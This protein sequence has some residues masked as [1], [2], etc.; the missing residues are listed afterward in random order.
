MTAD[1]ET[2][3]ENNEQPNAQTTSYKDFSENK[4][5]HA[6]KSGLTST[7]FATK[8]T[9]GL[10]TEQQ[11]DQVDENH[12]VFRRGSTQI[13]VQTYAASSASDVIDESDEESLKH[14]S[15]TLFSILLGM[16][17]LIIT[18]VIKLSSSITNRVDYYVSQVYVLTLFAMG[19]TWTSYYSFVGLLRHG[20]QLKFSKNNQSSNRWL[21]GVVILFGFGI[22]L[23][24]GLE[25]LSYLAI[26][27]S[28]CKQNQ[29]SAALSMLNI[30]F[31]L[32][33]VRY[34]FRFSKVYIRNCN[35][36]SR[37]GLMYI[38]S[39]NLSIWIMAIIDETLHALNSSSSSDDTHDEH[40]ESTTHIQTA[41]QIWNGSGAAELKSS[42]EHGSDDSCTCHTDFCNIVDIAE[43]FLFPFVIEFSL[44]ASCLLYVTWSN[45]G[46]Q[47]PPCEGVVKP[48]YKLHNSY[49]GMFFGAVVFFTC[50]IFIILLGTSSS[51]DAD[52]DYFTESQQLV[53]YNSFLIGVESCMLLACIAG[54]Y[55]FLRN[56]RPL[57][58]SL[59]LDKVLLMICLLGP[60]TL[61]MFSLT[62]VITSSENKIPTWA[63]TVVQPLIDII[64]SILQIILIL[65][66]MRREP[67]TSASS[68]EIAADLRHGIHEHLRRHNSDDGQ[69]SSSTVTFNNKTY[70]RSRRNSITSVVSRLANAQAQQNLTV[71]IAGL[72]GHLP[73]TNQAFVADEEIKRRVEIQET[74]QIVIT[75]EDDDSVQEQNNGLEDKPQ[76][77]VNRDDELRDIEASNNELP[78]DKQAIYKIV[79][80]TRLARPTGERLVVRGVILFLLICNAT[81]WLF[82]SLD[83]TAFT[84]YTFQSIFYGEGAWTTILMICRPLNIFFRMHSAGCL[85]EIWSFA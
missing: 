56:R 67:V 33:Q 14:S 63:L 54:F 70:L 80:E 76:D 62:A 68:K 59:M 85:F 15:I 52:K 39:V 36:G 82:M 1:A 8:S 5:K 44:V 61:N 7:T 83:G 11:I 69:Q 74:P 22:V 20:L 25:F 66:G 42:S 45:V 75:S 79:T 72:H 26:D 84:V 46:K 78:L 41:T 49:S 71:D 21:K 29:I 77:T 35:G 60:L 4:N 24:D 50:V 17:I 55:L 57:E 31:V 28:Q 43:K 65:Y 18:L 40:E 12:Y 6:D 3:E 27:I 34:L 9:F 58:E 64:Q 37:T 81:L 48:S 51:N 23:K 13:H 16:L 38:I 30:L 73:Q 2:Q 19:F 10:R 53:L 32:S 47:P